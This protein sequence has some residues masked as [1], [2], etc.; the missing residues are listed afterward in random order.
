MMLTGPFAQRQAGG[1][2]LDGVWPG[3]YW[4]GW[5]PQEHAATGCA[6][7][8]RLLR[9]ARSPDLAAAGARGGAALAPAGVPVSRHGGGER[10][11]ACHSFVLG[12]TSQRCLSLQHGL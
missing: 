10:N 11:G 1:T 12:D 2:A 7:L 4:T 6:A 3:V 5:V 9:A 8:A